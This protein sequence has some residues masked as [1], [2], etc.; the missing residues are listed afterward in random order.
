M[1][2]GQPQTTLVENTASTTL[3][4]TTGT[5]IWWYGRV[6]GH[7]LEDER[8]A[9]LRKYT[10]DGNQYLTFVKRRSK[11]VLRPSQKREVIQ[12][13]F[14]EFDVIIPEL[15]VIPDR[16]RHPDRYQNP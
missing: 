2:M 9:D 10:P 6:K 1:K 8:T 14:A 4:F 15:A 11:K 12:N 3:S 7:E 16:S 5:S 13:V